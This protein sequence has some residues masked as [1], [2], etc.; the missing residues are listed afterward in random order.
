MRKPNIY[1]SIVATT[2]VGASV[3]LADNWIQDAASGCSV[4]NPSPVEHETIVWRGSIEDGKASGYGI[5]TWRV[6]GKKSEQALGQ[7][8]DGR[9]HGYAV[10]THVSGA[11]YE[12]EWVS[13]AKN[14]CGIYT[15]PDGARFVGEYRNDQR[16]HGR[17]FL[18]DGAPQK[19]IASAMSR[20]LSYE[21]EDSAIAARKA[22]T[23]A[24]IENP[25]LPRKKKPAASK[26]NPKTCKG[27]KSKRC[28]TKAGQPAACKPCAA[29][30]APEDPSAK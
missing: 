17:I 6:R 21:A 1:L 30:E 22:A 8:R 2:L 20:E 16:S 15:W 28:K 4:W 11:R 29:A 27:K 25:R 3:S 23:R 13:G 26:P 5:A 19:Q 12:G 7:W 9:L 14:G 18:A 10:W 24:K